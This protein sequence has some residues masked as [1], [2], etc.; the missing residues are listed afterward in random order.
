MLICSGC[1]S[2]SQKSDLN[3]FNTLYQAGQ[4]AEAADVQLLAKGNKVNHPAQLLEVLQ[5]GAA[6]RAG[7]RLDESNELFDEAEEIIKQHDE[8]LLASKSVSTVGATLV[9]DT[10]LDYAGY[11]YDGVMVNTYKALNLWKQGE[12]DARVEFN[13]AVE[14]QDRARRSGL[15]N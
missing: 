6:L 10:V 14:R 11:E 9:N 3:K 2:T 8:K 13:R 15:L 4:Y 1:A 7:E 12:A 5:A